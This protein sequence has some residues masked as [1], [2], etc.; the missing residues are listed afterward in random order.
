MICGGSNFLLLSQLDQMTA[1]VEEEMV[2]V[3]YAVKG[4]IS[5]LFLALQPVARA[6]AESIYNVICNRVL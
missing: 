3:R 4:V 1:S 5:V 2:Y 6:N